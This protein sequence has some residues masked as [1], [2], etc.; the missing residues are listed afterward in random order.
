MVF[1]FWAATF[2]VAAQNTDTRIRLST[3]IEK[4]IVDDLDAS[5]EYEHR[6]DQQLTAFDKAFIEPAISYNIAKPLRIGL[7]YRIILDQNKVREK[8]Y[9]QRVGT[10]IRYDFKFDDFEFKIKTALQYGFDELTDASISYDQKLVN[11]NAIEIEYNIFGSKITPFVSYEFFYHLNNP[12]GAIIN[13]W[14]F[15]TGGSYKISKSSKVQAY[16][17]FENE[18]NVANPVDANIFG[19]SYSHNL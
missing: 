2:S 6:F 15:K 1:I 17:L 18:F 13:Q 14:R 10:Y 12:N 19:L 11:R 4:E 16:W 9:K 5:M 7:S 8:Q 3:K